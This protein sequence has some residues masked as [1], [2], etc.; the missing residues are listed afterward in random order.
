MS[1][2]YTIFYYL[3]W[4]DIRKNICSLTSKKRKKLD[5]SVNLG[6]G[7]NGKSAAFRLQRAM[8]PE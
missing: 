3:C 6:P 5:D 7:K 2:I 8:E 1:L 4:Q